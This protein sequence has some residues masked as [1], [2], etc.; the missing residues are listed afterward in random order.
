MSTTC[1]QFSYD[2][3]G[4]LQQAVPN[5]VTLN[6]SYDT[7]GRRYKLAT[8]LTTTAY[9]YDG[10]NP[11]ETVLD[12]LTSHPTSY[13]AGLGLDDFFSETLWNGVSNVN[14]SFLRDALGSTVAV[15]DSR[16]NV[17]D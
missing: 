3:R 16:G 4:N 5:G 10:L 6:Y 7:L 12:G 1:P 13:L 2:A 11:V 8:G 17:L 15:T 9:Q 14:E